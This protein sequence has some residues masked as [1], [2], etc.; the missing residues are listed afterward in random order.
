MS[1]LRRIA[2]IVWLC[3]MA[4]LLIAITVAASLGLLGPASH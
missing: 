1:K 3:A 4:A 2:V